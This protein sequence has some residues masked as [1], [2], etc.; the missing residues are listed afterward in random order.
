M[1]KGSLLWQTGKEDHLVP[2]VFQHDAKLDEDVV[3]WSLEGLVTH[4]MAARSNVAKIRKYVETEMRKVRKVL[5]RDIDHLMIHQYD[6]ELVFNE[7]CSCNLLPT[8]VRD[9]I[10]RFLTEVPTPT[11]SVQTFAYPPAAPPPQKSS[12]GKE[13]EEEE[14]EP[15]HPRSSSSSSSSSSEEEEVRKRKTPPPPQHEEECSAS[16]EEEEDSVM[17]QVLM[18]TR[19]IDTLLPVLDR[20]EHDILADD[21]EKVSL[22][23][24]IRNLIRSI[25]RQKILRVCTD[26]EPSEAGEP[27]DDDSPSVSVTQ[28]AQELGYVLQPSHTPDGERARKDIGYLAAKYYAELHDGRLPPQMYVTLQGGT[29]ILVN[30]WTLNNCHNTLDRAIHTV[31]SVKE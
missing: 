15:F 16:A 13:E 17:D 28:R 8:D 19:L 9:T 18:T 31:L 12:K 25:P 23:L 11:K 7:L 21:A 29:R 26:A 5:Q 24:F 10:M 6:L 1:K 2:L 4:F 22:K 3:Y 14:D 30:K 27:L 20:R